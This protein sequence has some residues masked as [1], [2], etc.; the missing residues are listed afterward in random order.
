MDGWSKELLYCV[1]KGGWMGGW[2]YISDISPY[3]I[4]E[5]PLKHLNRKLA[6]NIYLH[7]L[8]KFF[9]FRIPHSS[10]SHQAERQ[11]RQRCQ[12]STGA[13]SA[14]LWHPRQTR[15]CER[16]RLQLLGITVYQ[17]KWLWLE[18]DLFSTV[19]IWR[20]FYYKCFNYSCDLNVQVNDCTIKIKLIT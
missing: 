14:L 13:D 1:T 10:F 5:E 19:L 17:F 15:R 4:C 11:V 9:R 6:P 2:V 8:A 16:K 20:V 18:Q 7:R 12:I 3:I